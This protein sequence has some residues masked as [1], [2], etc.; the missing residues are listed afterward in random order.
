MVYAAMA[1]TTVTVSVEA[2]VLF[3]AELR[4]ISGFSPPTTWASRK[5]RGKYVN[6]HASPIVVS[7]ISDE[8]LL[9]MELE[10]KQ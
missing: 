6:Y 2:H 9:T 4:L 5:R 7:S 10:D 8:D 3:Y 1:T